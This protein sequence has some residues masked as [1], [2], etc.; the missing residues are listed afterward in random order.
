MPFKILPDTA[1]ADV[2]FEATGTS[3]NEL[4]ESACV[5]TS[6]VM[7]DLKTVT[8]KKKKKFSKS[9]AKLD[10]LL[11][12][13][14]D[15]LVFLKDADNLIFSKFSVKIKEGT[16]NHAEVTASGQKIDQKSMSLRNDIK[17]V[18]WHLFELQ[19]T[20]SGWSAKVLLDV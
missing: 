3:L 7:A 10:R 20:K 13:V 5:A 19:K 4:F 17:A 6:D 14:L 11:Y 16:P 15:E 8:Q 2:A 1:T 12:D 9:N 18:T